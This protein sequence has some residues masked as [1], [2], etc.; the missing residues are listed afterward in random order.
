MGQDMAK[1]PRP[2]RT[3]G[4]H[5]NA[6]VPILLQRPCGNLSKWRE[7]PRA[8][9]QYTRNYL[10]SAGSSSSFFSAAFLVDFRAGFF[11]SAPSVSSAF[12]VDFRAGFFSSPSPASSV[13]LEDLRA[14]FF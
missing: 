9:G 14:G 13:F 12:L 2:F 10:D 3:D 6:R 11:S 7:H 4:A 8:T 5:A 1:A